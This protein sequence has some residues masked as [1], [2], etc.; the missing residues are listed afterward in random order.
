MPCVFFLRHFILLVEDSMNSTMRL[1]S[2]IIGIM[3]AHVA[4]ATTAEDQNEPPMLLR[5]GWQVQSSALVPEDGKQISSPQFTPE[6]W[7]PTTIPATVLTTLTRNKVYPDMRVGL[8][9]LR[10]PDASEEFNQRH[11]LTQYSHL[12]NQQNPWA[13]PYWY[14]T[15]F[16]LPSSIDGKRVWLTFNGIN[17]RAD[18][19]LNGVQI[20]DRDHMVGSFSRYRFDIT[21]A[22]RK[23]KNCLAVK[24]HLVDHPGVPDTQLEALGPVREYHKEIMKDVALIFS[25][26]YDCMPTVPDRTM[27]IWQDVLVEMSGPVVIRDPFIVTDLPLPKTDVAYLTVSANVVNATSQPQKGLFEGTISETG[28][29]F[30]REV[31]LAPGESK[32]IVFSAEDGP[33]PIMTN[34]RL[35]WPRNY[36][37]QNLYRMNLDFRQG[38]QLSD[39]KSVTFGVRK[40]TKEIHTLNNFHGLR[41]HIN[42]QRVFCQG[43]YIQPEL[44]HDWDARRMETEIRYLTEANMNLVY[45]EDVANPPDA[46]LDL[47]DRYGLMC[48]NC[49]YGCHWMVPGSDFPNDLELLERSTIDIIQRY[50][51]HPS[52]VLYMAMNEGDTREA[53]YTM[54]RKHILELDGTRLHIPSGSFPDHRGTNAADIYEDYRK[55]VPEWIKADT[56]VGMTDEG[57]KTYGWEEPSQYFRW[58]REGKTWMFKME[59]GS[60]SVPPVDSVRRFIPDLWDAK[61]G[62]HFPLTPTWAHHGTN[63][64]YEPYDKA[65]RQ[66]HGE[67]VSVED[68]CMKGHLVTADEHRAMFEAVNHRLWDVTSGFTQWKINACWPDANWQLYDWYLRPMVSYYAVKKACEPLHIQLCPLDNT[69]AVINHR[70]EP[71]QELKVKVRVYDFTMHLRW[72][73]TQNVSLAANSYK[74]VLTIPNLSDL[75]PLYFVKLELSQTDGRLVSD[76]FYWQS[77]DPFDLKL[78]GKLPPVALTS[79][80]EITDQG[81]EKVVTVTIKNPTDRLA[82]FTHLALTQR[83]SGDEILPVFWD[84]N[85]FSLLP[86]ESKTVQARMATNAVAS[87]DLSLEI[88]GWNI[89][90]DYECLNLTSSKIHAKCHEP[91]IVTASIRNTFLDGSPVEF[92]VD[93]T[94]FETKRLWARDNQTREVTFQWTPTTPG[95][96][97]IQIGKKSASI[98]IE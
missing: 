11:N 85:Y 30:Q 13:T 77:Q 87:Q 83:T 61:P 33:Q 48:G 35:W 28:V 38:G 96:H 19:W 23:D 59:N 80:Y 76:N 4:L 5:Q 86:G 21:N 73:N 69:I 56:P 31:E 20:A 79:S 16:E 74:E 63:M 95:I 43:G 36:G 14:R 26:G 71:T 12:P 75:T 62:P 24:I 45:F 68:Y 25:V 34:P 15:E 8:N 10:I 88:G 97:T 70:L 50:R 40:I 57:C 49:F 64:Y 27:G 44:M 67:P 82:L 54:W 66:L 46:F 92:C 58:V 6:H 91:V 3:L 72:E 65:V 94:V 41:L 29:K 9:V 60:A 47:C 22:A 84:D 89:Q 7:Y 32:R 81:N 1:A 37:A 42:G 17:Y 93:G 18:V 51:N 53:V 39:S 2:M 78:L 55:D 98:T 90:S 52:L